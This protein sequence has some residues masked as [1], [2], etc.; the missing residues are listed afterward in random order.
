MGCGKRERDSVGE[1]GL[2]GAIEDG[3]KCGVDIE[4][5]EIGGG[6]GLFFSSLFQYIKCFGVVHVMLTHF[7]SW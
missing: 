1:E 2:I 7:G 6:Y 5:R 4:A 3:C